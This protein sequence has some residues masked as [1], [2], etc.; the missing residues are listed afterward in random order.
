MA[1]VGDFGCDVFNHTDHR[2]MAVCEL[3]NVSALAK[4]VFRHGRFSVLLAA[5][6]RDGAPRFSTLGANSR[7]VLGRNADCV[8]RGNYWNANGHWL[9]PLDALGAALGKELCHFEQSRNARRAFL[10]SRETWC[11]SEL[12]FLKV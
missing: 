12:R 7:I 4:L 5:D 10:R 1:E 8:G 11:L 6:I 3:P 2:A 9:E